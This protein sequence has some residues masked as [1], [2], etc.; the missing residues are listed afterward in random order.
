MPQ[1]RIRLTAARN[2][3]LPPVCMCCGAPAALYK[4]QQFIWAPAWSYVFG[5]LGYRFYW[6]ARM[7]GPLCA[8]HRHHWTWRWALPLC[9]LLL[10]IAAAF[11]SH[12][13]LD[14]THGQAVAHAWRGW[15]YGCAA[16]AFAV[17]FVLF[18]ILRRSGVHPI[19]MDYDSITFAGVADAFAEA[20][21]NPRLPAA[22]RRGR[23][24]R[25]ANVEN[26]LPVDEP[27]SREWRR[28]ISR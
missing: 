22:Q 8:A 24:V 17:W 14:I 27:E 11:G 4:R 10:G 21:A 9:L 2:E 26:V 20:V 12:V 7:E 5:P 1:V 16:V 19:R 6:R 3:G 15:I 23:A 13:Y 25:S 28:D 18:Q